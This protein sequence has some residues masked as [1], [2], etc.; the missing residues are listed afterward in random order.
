[1]YW[2]PEWKKRITPINTVIRCAIKFS[3]S[4]WKRSKM[5]KN[6]LRLT[7]ESTSW[8]PE[9]AQNRG[10]S[11]ATGCRKKS[12]VWN[13][14]CCKALSTWWS[15]KSKFSFNLQPTNRIITFLPGPSSRRR[16]PSHACSPT[17]SPDASSCC[18]GS[19]TK[20]FCQLVS[21]ESFAAKWRTRSQRLRWKQHLPLSPTGD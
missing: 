5:P 15:P 18:S 4:W 16:S 9:S 1:M 11:Q 13:S 8:E 6:S 19:S 10:C 21:P 3:T 12:S 7:T 17:S 2:T 20:S 14:C